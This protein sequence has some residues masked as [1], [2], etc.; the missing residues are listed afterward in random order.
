MAVAVIDGDVFVEGTLVED[1]KT[2]LTKQ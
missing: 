1:K 2:E